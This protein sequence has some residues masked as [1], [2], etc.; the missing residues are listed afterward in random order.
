M[1]FPSLKKILTHKV[2]RGPG[3]ARGSTV[4]PTSTETVGVPT[5]GGM[6]CLAV[7]VFQ[8]KDNKDALSLTK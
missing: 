3:E 7:N 6:L 5:F 8:V 1:I 2:H 4:H